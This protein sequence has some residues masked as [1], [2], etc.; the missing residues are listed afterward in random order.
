[1]SQ[2][3]VE[4]IL[5]YLAIAEAR[6]IDPWLRDDLR[7]AWLTVLYAARA[8]SQPFI[9]AT[10]RVLGIHPDRLQAAIEARRHAL[11]GSLYDAVMNSLPPKKPAVSVTSP[12]PAKKRA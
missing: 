9:L 4:R 6:E 5:A 10:Y 8:Y 12:I 2:P 11:L 1:M 3:Q 7:I